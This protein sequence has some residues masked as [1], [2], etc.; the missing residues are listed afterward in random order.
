M[1]NFLNF[2][3][4]SSLDLQIHLKFSTFP[5]YVIFQHFKLLILLSF[6]ILFPG[7]L[8]FSVSIGFHRFFFQ[9][10]VYTTLSS[11]NVYS[12]FMN[13]SRYVRFVDK[14]VDVNEGILRA[15]GFV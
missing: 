3:S 5:R 11:F 8:A 6:G 13:G 9:N 14:N 4:P 7:F 1:F 10:S 15:N 12:F 2:Y